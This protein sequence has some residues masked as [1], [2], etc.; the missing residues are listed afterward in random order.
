MSSSSLQP[1]LALLGYPIE[2][3]PT[4]YITEKAFRDN[5][6]DWRYLTLEVSP[7]DLEDAVRGMR[8]MGFAGGNITPPHERPIVE[9]LER[10]TPAAELIGAVNVL[11][12][13]ENGLIGENT[14][15]KA[16]IEVIRDSIDPAGKK[17]V[18]LGAGRIAR[19]IC[20]ELALCGVEQLTIVNR[21]ESKAV[22]LAELIAEKTNINV[23]G[24]GWEEPFSLPEG[25]DILVQ[26]TAISDDDSQAEPNLDSESLSK[27]TLVVDVTIDPPHT[28][29]LRRA[30][31][32][33][34]KTIDGPAI[35]VRQ[36][37]VNIRLWTG[38]DVDLNILRESLEEFLEL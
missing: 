9:I 13:D 23:T 25:T 24:H 37:A 18:V 4:Q 7:A 32:F 15:G 38:I 8:A 29:L 19:A 16:A 30:E 35:L 5:S 11:K 28:R 17:V 33:G 22:E 36:A 1:V 26:A 14:E 3:N 10:T 2:G 12:R 31:R 21:T 20:V 27:E 34:C 6:L